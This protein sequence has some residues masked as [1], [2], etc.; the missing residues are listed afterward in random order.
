VKNT[1]RRPARLVMAGLF[2]LTGGAFAGPTSTRIDA[3]LPLTFEENVGQ[4]DNQVKY[5]SRGRGYALFLTADSAVLE[6][7]RPADAR[8]VRM[9]FAGAN[10][11]TRVKGLDPTAGR[12]NYLTG[13]DSA[14]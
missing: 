5:L 2:V 10:P 12:S 14:Q 6:A 9:R 7:G 4:S 11:G 8:V 3:R 13:G 1:L